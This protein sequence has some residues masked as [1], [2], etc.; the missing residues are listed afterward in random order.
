MDN[1]P[2]M[3]AMVLERQGSIDERPLRLQSVPIP[4]PAAGQIRIRV[5]ACGICRTDLHVIEGELPDVPLPLIPGHQI[6][7]EVDK[8]GEGCARFAVGDRAG[9]A[10]LRGTDGDC[11]QCQR[12]RE[13]LCENAR[14]TGYHE[15]GGYAEF[16]VVDEE[17]AYPL[18][19]E[20]SDEAA[21]PLLCAGLIGYRALA[22]AA[23]PARGRLLL[24]GFGSSAHI[25]IQLALH[26]G[27]DVYVVTREAKHRELALRLG[28]KWASGDFESMPGKADGAILFAPA[29]DLVPAAMRRLERGGILSI[30]GIYLSDVPA[31]NYERE[32]FYEREIRSVTANTRADGREL[33]VEAVD[34]GVQPQITTYR[35]EDANQALIDL[36]HDR[37]AGTGVLLLSS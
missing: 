16:A 28:A 31:M 2:L 22:R 4:E 26:R 20:F 9:I 5:H 29:G 34:A 10:W 27:Y 15:N 8:L 13:N 25:V 6:V 12:G 37:I 24:I 19:D 32:L 3:R 36:K 18:P 14:F 1:V 30:A 35:L 17:F 33:F 7:G 21:A 23:V 11:F